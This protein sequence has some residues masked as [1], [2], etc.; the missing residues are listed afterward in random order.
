MSHEDE[1]RAFL[2]AIREAPDD[3]VPRL[4]YADWLD[5]HGDAARAEFVRVQCQLARLPS[6]DE[7]RAELEKR[8][9]ESLAANRDAWLGPLAKVL[10]HDQCTFRRG[11]PEGLSIRPKA[12]VE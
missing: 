2:E 5:D 11:F 8:E 1:G 4:V 7:R 6:E 9:R 10:R 12:M 3:D